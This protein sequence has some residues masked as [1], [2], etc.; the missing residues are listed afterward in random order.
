[1]EAKETPFLLDIP[2]VLG[3]AE[4][5]EIRDPGVADMTIVD[6]TEI[7]DHPIDGLAGFTT[8]KMETF[9]GTAHLQL[10]KAVFRDQLVAEF[11]VVGT[12]L[13]HHIRAVGSR[14]RVFL[15]ECPLDTEAHPDGLEGMAEDPVPVQRPLIGG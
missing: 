3:V 4:L 15:R 2:G 10:G 8:A 13:P 5:Q 11:R 14:K 6:T 1:M 7:I 9:C 12:R